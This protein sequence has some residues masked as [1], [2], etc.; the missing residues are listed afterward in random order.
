MRKLTALL[1]IFCLAVST[2][3]AAEFSAQSAYNWLSSQSDSEGSFNSNTADTSWAVLAMNKAGTM[4]ALAER[5]LEWIFSQQSA[6]Y[7][8]PSSPCKSKDTAMAML[9]MNKLQRLDNMTEIQDALKKMLIPSSMSGQWLLEVSTDKTGTCKLEW[10]INGQAKEKTVAVDKGRF[11][12]CSN[13]YFLNL[14]DCVSTALLNNPGISVKVN[15][16]GIEGGKIIT[17]VYRNANSFY[18]L[19]SAS[20]DTADIVINNGCFG[21]GPG[22]SSCKKDPSMYAAW[23]A[24]ET[25]MTLDVKM[26]L[27]DA[28]SEE[29]AED[30]ALLYMGT[31]DSRYLAALKQ[32]QKT[33]GSFDRSV[34]KTA[35]AVMALKEDSAYSEQA[36]KAMDWL[37]TKQKADGSFGTV[38]ETS[39]VLYAAFADGVEAPPSDYVPPAAICIEDGF[40]DFDA[41]EDSINCPLDCPEEE[42]EDFE[43]T[44][45]DCQVNS[46]CEIDY[47]E[48]SE[49]CPEDCSC[50]DGKCDDYESS[51]GTCEEDCAASEEPSCGDGDCNG[52]EDEDSCPDDCADQLSTDN[53]GSVKWI[54]VALIVLI[55][56]AGGIF[57][58][59]KLGLIKSPGAA[60][61]SKPGYSFPRPVGMPPMGPSKVPPMKQMTSS[62]RPSGG[63]SRPAAKSKDEE[64]DKSLA[65]ARKLLGK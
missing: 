39:A 44:F 34:M 16:A 30:N 10:E 33:D 7:C 42:E 43:D 4:S 6:T 62:S 23:A 53:G 27:M 40:C 3:T 58:G 46:D 50:G 55:I 37:K 1:I 63:F 56:V 57:A 31:K 12:E 52:D 25:L 51:E 19:S 22:D 35:L 5:S 29:S 21:A 28:Y 41:G 18:V 61:S 45:S 2:A 14:K 60:K 24:K 49:N 8:F 9:A 59:K 17:L 26:Y 65:E 38:S 15:C 48:T 64:L 36:T 11:T 13:S 47:G 20:G 54:I 32:I